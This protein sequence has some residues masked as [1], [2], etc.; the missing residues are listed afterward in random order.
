[1]CIYFHTVLSSVNYS[2]KTTLRRTTK[3]TEL[4]SPQLPMTSWVF[5]ICSQLS[6]LYIPYIVMYNGMWHTISHVMYNRVFWSKHFF[7][8]GFK[9]RPLHSTF[10]EY[11]LCWTIIWEW[12]LEKSVGLE[13]RLRFPIWL[14][15]H[16][17]LMSFPGSL[18]LSWQDCEWQRIIS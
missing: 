15:S 17:I 9:M 16:I 6:V 1:M 13:D 12:M 5:C 2:P 11:L 8:Y 18:L 4:Q 3:K 7:Y 14:Y 10:H